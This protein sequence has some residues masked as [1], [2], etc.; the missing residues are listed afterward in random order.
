MYR[1]NGAPKMT[2]G[3]G[4]WTTVSRPRRIGMTVW[5]GRDPYE[6]D[7][8]V[9]FSKFMDDISV[10]GDIAKLNQM[11]MGSALNQPPTVMIDGQVPVKGIKWVITSIDWGDDVY[12]DAAGRQRQDAVVHLMQYVKEERVDVIGK[13]PT[14]TP[15]RWTV[16]KG[17][18]LRSVAARVYG[19]SSQWK[20]I[21]AAQV[22]P[23]RTTGDKPLTPGHPTTLRIP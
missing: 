20:A 3:G 13:D 15:A 9:L 7:V 5:N 18:T 17:D 16:R 1:G 6:M 12:W 23:L 11:Q 14:P 19:D 2:A 4:G 22:P 8:P 10:E 21:A